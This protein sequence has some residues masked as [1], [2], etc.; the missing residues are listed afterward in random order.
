MLPT[1]RVT[2]LKSLPWFKGLENEENLNISGK[3]IQQLRKLLIDKKLSVVELTNYYLNRIAQFD[4]RINSYITISSQ[5][6]KDAEALDQKISR[7]EALNFSLLGMPVGIKDMLCTKGLLTTAGSKM[8]STFVPPYDATVVARLK[9]QG[10]I[11]LGK[12]N[13]DEF[14]MGSSNETSY[15]GPVKNPWNLEYVS[16]GSSGGSAAAQAAELALFTIGTDTGGSIRQPASF[17]GVVG[18]KPTYGRVS[19]Y[20]IVSYASSLDQAGPLANCVEDA[21]LILETIS[22]QDPLDSTTS[23][24]KVE[25]WSQN[26]DLNLKGF[27]VGVLPA[28]SLH[29]DVQNTFSDSIQ[30]LKKMG[31]EVKEISIPLAAYGIP[32][33]YLIASSEA[34]SNLARYDGVKYGYRAEFKNLSSMELADFYART[35]SE[36]F[37]KEVQR[38]I[39][40]GT[41]CLSSGYYE[42]YY[43][44]ASQVRRLIYNQYL[45]AFKTCDVLLSPVAASPAF[46]LGE[47]ISDPLTMYLNDIFTITTN[48]AGLPGMSVPFG[49][50][51]LGLPIGVQVVAAH[52][53]E[54]KM[55]N[56][57]FALESQAPTKG[58]RPHDL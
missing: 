36:G 17:C 35:R 34:S 19:R 55:L 2:F 47:R 45:E 7:G 25:K 22:G 11:V 42:A 9:N 21:A 15:F 53:Q 31:A 50:S 18:V 52:F 10:A 27:R 58:V 49:M 24:Q 38:R 14:A 30:T 4:S 8:L 40:L 57:A 5:A 23:P 28:D 54:Q 26:L 39:M 56:V 1:T 33:Y 13:Q 32:V 46:K 20:G 48:L 3:S 43:N 29:P 51:K 37:G 12:L 41:Y 16:G 44:K 6:L